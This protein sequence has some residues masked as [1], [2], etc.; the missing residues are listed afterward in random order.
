MKKYYYRYLIVTLLF[1]VIT[2]YIIE[3]NKPSFTNTVNKQTITQISTN[4][5]IFEY[6]SQSLNKFIEKV[7]EIDGVLK[8]IKFQNN[9]HTLYLTDENNTAYILCELQQDQ[10]KKTKNLSIG[11]KVRIKGV[12]KGHLKDIILLN[13]VIL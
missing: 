13:C 4:D 7:I 10:F 3:F 1:V 5:L 6:K 8:E 2:F 11:K 12:L 9:V